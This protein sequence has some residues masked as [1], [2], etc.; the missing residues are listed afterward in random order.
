MSGYIRDARRHSVFRSHRTK[1]STAEGREYEMFIISRTEP[2]R[3][4]RTRPCPTGTR[5][6]GVLQQ[7]VAEVRRLYT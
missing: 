5:P 3:L 1:A 4:D 6:C 2:E 7:G